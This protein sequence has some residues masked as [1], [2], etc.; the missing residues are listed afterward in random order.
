M[1]KLDMEKDKHSSKSPETSQRAITRS[2]SLFEQMEFNGNV[3][4]VFSLI[5]DSTNPRI[6][7]L[8]TWLIVDYAI[9][10]LL[11][12]GLNLNEYRSAYFKPLSDSFERNLSLLFNVIKEQRDL[13]SRP[14]D[15]SLHLPKDF[16]MFCYAN[17]PEEFK[18]LENLEYKF[19]AWIQSQNLIVRPSGDMSKFRFVTDEWVEV[20]KGIDADWKAKAERL[21][22]GRN[23]AAHSFD[24]NELFKA[25]GLNGNEEN[26][27]KL[28]KQ[29]CGDLLK[30]LLGISAKSEI[31]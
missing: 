2:I 14:T 30:F 24:S 23:S 31:T 27:L 8:E 7:V 1:E 6:I 3:E 16:F 17:F 5:D 12:F 28:L 13:P 4:R 15:Y 22:K 18:V 19:Y 29:E 26:R 11:I 20:V 25:F 10:Q 9:R 21:N